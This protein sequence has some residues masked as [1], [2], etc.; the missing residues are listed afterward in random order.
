MFIAILLIFLLT[1]SGLVL[2]YLYD[3]DAPMLVRLSSG[4]IVGSAIFGLIIFLIACFFGFSSATIL[5]SLLISISPI[6]LLTNRNIHEKF[7]HDWRK[8]SGKMQGATFAKL[9]P[10]AYYVCILAVLYFFFERVMLV[11]TDGIF[12]GASQNLGDLPFHLGAIFSF[13]EGNNFPP[14][15]PSFWGAKFTYP[16]MSDLIVACFVKLGASVQAA[17]L[18]QNVALGFSL[19]VLLEWFTVKIT[20]NKLAGKIAPLLL[21]FCG[22]LGF[23][24][25][26]REFWQDGRGFFDFIWNLKRDYTIN[27]ETFRWGNSLVVLF[28]TQRGLLLGMPLTLIVLTKMFQVFTDDEKKNETVALI[29]IGLLAGTLPLIHVHSLVVLFLASA[30]LVI[31]NIKNLKL[32]LIFSV[33]VCAIA[34]PELAWS[35]TGSATNLSKFIELHFGWDK[36]EEYFILFWLKNLGLFIPLLLIAWFWMINE[37][38][39]DDETENSYPPRRTFALFIFYIPFLLCFIIPNLVKLAPWE[40][41]NIKVLIYWFVGSVPFVAWLIADLWKRDWMLKIVAAIC[42][43]CL[44]L[45]GTIDVWRQISGAVNYGIFNKDAVKIGEQIKQKVATNAIFLNAPTYN[46]AVV[47]SGRPSVMRYSGHLSSYGIDYTERERDVKLI[48]EGVGTSEL[49]MSKYGVEYVII[50]PE[51]TNSMPVNSE[52]FAKFPKIAES[53]NY[54]IYDVR[55]K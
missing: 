24:V 23:L 17:M 12:T 31:F 42:L 48:Y 21:L 43:I 8:A 45:S 36:K 1:V 39:S 10:F 44:T 55:K 19:V 52:F 6:A 46:S 13:T 35:L 38:K 22:G 9:L 29:I 14:Q 15:N 25:F 49:L 34:V 41:D 32:W 16:F 27:N 47:L 26:F 5:I 4:N 54:Q 30:T 3:A 18:V 7:A 11:K 51:E 20:E 2:T 33:A 28:A 50:S 37:K 53:G 40:W